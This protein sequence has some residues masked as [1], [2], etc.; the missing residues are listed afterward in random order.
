MIKIRNFFIAL[1]TSAAVVIIIDIIGF[2]YFSDLSFISGWLSCATFYFLM[3]YLKKVDI[4]YDNELK[5]EKIK[6][7]ESENK[8]LKIQIGEIN[9][10]ITTERCMRKN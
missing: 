8:F 9:S 3:K 2:I 4:I 6:S 5:D 7:L 10:Q 1:I